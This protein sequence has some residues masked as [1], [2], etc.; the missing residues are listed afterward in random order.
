MILTNQFL[1]IEFR[2]VANYPYLDAT[3]KTLAK[4][5]GTDVKAGVEQG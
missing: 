3:V 1:K 4:F 2:I 5:V